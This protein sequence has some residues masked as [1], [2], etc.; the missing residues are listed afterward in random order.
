MKNEPN[1]IRHR[2]NSGL[3]RRNEPS[4]KRVYSSLTYTEVKIGGLF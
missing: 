3:D 1:P 4:A 2:L